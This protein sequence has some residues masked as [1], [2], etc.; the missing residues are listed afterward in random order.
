[1][2]I[3]DDIVRYKLDIPVTID[4]EHKPI[5]CLADTTIKHHSTQHWLMMDI[6][7]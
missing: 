1:M 2:E 7:S 4:H 5:K 6:L 3:V